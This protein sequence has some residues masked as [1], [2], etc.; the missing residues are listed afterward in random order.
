MRRPSITTYFSL[1]TLVPLLLASVMLLALAL[2]TVDQSSEALG[3][4]MLSESGRRVE[5]DI[6]EY[7]SQTRR[8]SDLLTGLVVDGLLNPSDFTQWTQRLFIRLDTTPEVSSICF[9]NEFLQTVYLM[10]YPPDMEFG[11]GDIEEGVLTM[12]AY[13]AKAGGDIAS[14]PTRVYPYDPRTRPWWQIANESIE[15]VWTPAYQWFST[16]ERSDESTIAVAYTRTVMDREGRRQGVLSIDATLDQISRHLAGI[17]NNVGAFIVITDSQ[18]R[19]LGCSDS[20]V[21]TF[22]NVNQPVE[23]GHPVIDQ[24][25]ELLSKIDKNAEATQLITTSQGDQWVQ[26]ETLNIGPGA[27]WTMTIAVPDDNLLHQSKLAIQLM[28][29]LGA[30]FFVVSAALAIWLARRVTMPMKMLAN[31]AREVGGGAFD[32]RI[33]VR[34]TRE[35]D[36][37]STALNTMA[38]SLEERVSLRAQTDA[39]QEASQIKARLIAH[40]SHEFRTPLNAIIGYSEMLQE[41]AVQADRTQLAKDVGNILIASRHLLTLVNNLLD[42]SRVEAGKLR[43]DRVHF[44]IET[45]LRE[46]EMTVAPVVRAGDNALIVHAPPNIGTMYSDPARMKQVLINLLGNAAKFTFNG[47]IRLDVVPLGASD[48]QFSVIDTGIGMTEDQLRHA[49]EP[50]TQV[51]QSGHAKGDGAGLGLAITQQLCELLGGTIAV[52]SRPGEGTR[53][54]IQFP[55]NHQ[56]RTE[57]DVT[58]IPASKTVELKSDPDETKGT[59]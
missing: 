17:A 2:R 45:L 50:F 22:L 29:I 15:P 37:L 5:N 58:S 48:L 8:M 1:V 52:T 23:K 18:G 49:F 24:M 16:P 11:R 34:S 20:N 43:L 13:P 35:F 26:R 25:I 3:R 36:E 28:K 53:I 7:L 6:R 54:D 33:R 32:R 38:S 9:T 51:H 31:F 44:P 42:L 30:I 4:Q 56:G 41:D 27:S 55:R 12:R 46:I 39:A 40:V 59:R 21:K 47:E 10:R 14:T 19:V 57:I